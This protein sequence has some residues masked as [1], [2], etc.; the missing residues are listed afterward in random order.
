LRTYADALGAA[1]AFDAVEELFAALTS[2][3]VLTG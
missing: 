2:E 3:D 1:V